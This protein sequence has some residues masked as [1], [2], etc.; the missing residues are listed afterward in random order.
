MGWKSG[1]VQMHIWPLEHC[2]DPIGRMTYGPHVTAVC[3]SESWTARIAFSM[4]Y[5]HVYVHDITAHKQDPKK[6]VLQ[7]LRTE[8]HQKRFDCRK[9]WWKNMKSVCLDRAVAV[10]SPTG[11]VDI[12]DS[13]NPQPGQRGRVVA[14]SGVYDAGTGVRLEIAWFGQGRTSEVLLEK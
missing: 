14:G 10:R 4:H 13:D 9:V 8:V 7:R 11:V 5:E 1:N 3:P 6:S 12:F 2:L